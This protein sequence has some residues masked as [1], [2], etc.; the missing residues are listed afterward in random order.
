[1]RKKICRIIFLAIVLI[2]I[3]IGKSYCAEDGVEVEK[4]ENGL[5][6]KNVN[7]KIT[8]GVDVVGVEDELTRSLCVRL[9]QQSFGYTGTDITREMKIKTKIHIKKAIFNYYVYIGDKNDYTPVNLSGPLV[10]GPIAPSWTV[11]MS[12]L[13]NIYGYKDEYEKNDNTWD[14][15]LILS[16]ISGKDGEAKLSEQESEHQSFVLQIKSIYTG[17][18]GIEKGELVEV[19]NTRGE[20]EDIDFNDNVKEL[21]KQWLIDFKKDPGGFL[22]A[23]AMDFLTKYVGD[24]FQYVANLFQTCTDGTHKDHEVLYT[25]D[26]LKKDGETANNTDKSNTDKINISKTETDKSIG[27]RDKYTKVS[28][29]GE[30]E[31]V[32]A[33]ITVKKDANEDG[34]NDYSESTKIP[35]IAADLYGVAAGHIDFLDVNFLSGQKSKK[36]DGSG[37]RHSKSSL[38]TNFR[39]IAAA[40]VRI[41]IY[42]AS[43]ILLMGVI[44]YGINIVKNTFDNPKAKADAMAGIKRLSSALA[45]L[46]GTI[47]FMALCIFGSQALCNFIDSGNSYELPIRVDVEDTYSFST[48]ITGYVRYMSMTADVSEY[49]QKFGYSMTY[50]ILAIAN[51][52]ILVLMTRRMIVLWGLSILG[53]ILS[54]FKVFGRNGPMDFKKWAI[55]YVLYSS[56]QFGLTVIYMSMFWLFFKK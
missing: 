30:G 9:M 54:V 37:L 7:T 26:A 19:D 31:E 25:Y 36:L 33:R 39:N 6:A 24:V 50:I 12:D 11:S 8:I 34:D 4:L 3:G 22:L 17:P 5:I 14:A 20:M 32:V 41:A 52:V 21:Q 29:Y 16:P 55:T 53:P 2:I 23:K 49:G 48:T 1:M 27:N 35:V 40:L 46:I 18:D 42:I 51:V 15:I 13:K 43:A 10:K 56:V 38:W 47:L 28:I 44:W 45:I